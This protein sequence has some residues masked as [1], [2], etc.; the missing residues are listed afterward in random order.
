MARRAADDPTGWWVVV[1]MKDTREAKSRFGGA[2]GDRRQLAIVMARDT[3]CAVA[4][5]SCVEGVLVVC[6]REEDVESFKLPGVTVVVRPE[7]GINEA[8]VS[9]V[10]EVSGA[11]ATP[12]VAMLPGDLPYLRSAELDVALSRAASSPVACLADR[13]GTGTTL[14]TVRGGNAVRPAYGPDSFRAH[15]AEGAVD[16]GLPVWSGLRR[17][18]DVP[19]DLVVNASLGYRTR[20][21][22]ERRAR[23]LTPELERKGA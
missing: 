11:G 12:D 1:P 13:G 10:S 20:G 2:R 8:I 9:G 14:L 3:L 4:N 21:L 15:R 18:V 19:E 16:L 5:A 7:L 17:D 22:L 23:E 6:Q